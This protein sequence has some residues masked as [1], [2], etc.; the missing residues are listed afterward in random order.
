VSTSGEPSGTVAS[1]RVGGARRALTH[2]RLPSGEAGVSGAPPVATPGRP[3]REPLGGR[4]G[5]LLQCRGE[6]QGSRL[7]SR[8]WNTSA[9]QS[10]GTVSTAHRRMSGFSGGG[11]PQQ[12]PLTAC[13][14]G[15][16]PRRVASRSVMPCRREQLVLRDTPYSEDGEARGDPLEVGQRGAGIHRDVA[17]APGASC[18]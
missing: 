7:T 16:Q 3:L 15:G 2:A 13:G 9:N 18:K 8:D 14:L 6:S 11:V 10:Y 17:R 4:C 1:R 5:R 12:V